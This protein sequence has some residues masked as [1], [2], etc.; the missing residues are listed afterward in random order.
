MPGTSLDRGT[1]SSDHSAAN[2]Q[3]QTQGGL[4]EVWPGELR[5]KQGSHL[6]AV[7]IAYHEHWTTLHFTQDVADIETR[8]SDHDHLRATHEDDRRHR[9]C[10][11][12][13]NVTEEQ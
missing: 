3:G 2:P 9:R 5:F 1:G 8:N 7:R 6:E 11:A 13:L 12:E 4:D 10:E